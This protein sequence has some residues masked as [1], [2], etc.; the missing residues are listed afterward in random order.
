MSSHQ[1]FLPVRKKTLHCPSCKS[2]VREHVRKKDRLWRLIKSMWAFS[3]CGRRWRRDSP[4]PHERPLSSA[5]P[6]A[7][8]CQ[9]KRQWF[10]RRSCS[11]SWQ[12]GGSLQIVPAQQKLPAPHAQTRAHATTAV[13]PLA[14][15]ASSSSGRS[16]AR[17]LSRPPVCRSMPIQRVSFFLHLFLLR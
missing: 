3:L 11:S 5:P 7:V 17:K 9:G 2:G 13:L 6:A 16:V 14:S 8:H 15:T 12:N 1:N 10:A 4:I